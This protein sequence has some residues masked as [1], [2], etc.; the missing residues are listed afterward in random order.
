MSKL[1]RNYKFIYKSRGENMFTC[2]FGMGDWIA[3]YGWFLLLR[4]V[5]L[6]AYANI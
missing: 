4:L 6:S 1:E 5:V 2:R 3:A